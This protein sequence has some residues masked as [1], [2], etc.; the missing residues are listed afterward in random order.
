MQQLCEKIHAVQK[1]KGS[2]ARVD[3]RIWLCHKQNYR[4]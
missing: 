2:D 4:L 1:W 3:V